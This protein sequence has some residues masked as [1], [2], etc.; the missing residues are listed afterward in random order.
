LSCLRNFL[1]RTLESNDLNAVRSNGYSFQIEMTHKLWRQGMKVAEVPII[2]TERLR[3]KS[4][5]SG[6]I[7]REA[8]F[9]VIGLL[10][11]NGFRRSP[12][13]QRQAAAKPIEKNR[14]VPVSCFTLASTGGE[15]NRKGNLHA[16]TPFRQLPTM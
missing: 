16:L 11:R 12:G 4:K 9:M 10:V 15:G 7:V 5:M 2:F 8:I 14:K 3:G 6:H 13:P 1:C